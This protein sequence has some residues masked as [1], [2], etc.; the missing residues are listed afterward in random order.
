MIYVFYKKIKNLKKESQ[1]I[2]KTII[3]IC[4]IIFELEIRTKLT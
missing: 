2:N 4:N 1:T 3:H